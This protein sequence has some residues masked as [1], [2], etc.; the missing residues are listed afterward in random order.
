MGPACIWMGARPSL[1][2][3]ALPWLV[4][5]GFSLRMGPSAPTC[6]SL[7]SGFL[8]IRATQ[9]QLLWGLDCLAVL[10]RIL[11]PPGRHRESFGQLGSKREEGTS[12]TP[13]V[14][15]P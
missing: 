4:G 15:S 2:S 6:C 11:L 13:L 1:P 3:F 12:F 9:L 14:P 8:L 10:G 5:L 7:S